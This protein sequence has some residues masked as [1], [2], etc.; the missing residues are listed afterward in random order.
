MKL[1]NTAYS[2]VLPS[3]LLYKTPL[4][5]THTSCGLTEVRREATLNYLARWGSTQPTRAVHMS[6]AVGVIF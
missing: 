4:Q 5:Y 3:P 2:S 1:W 6:L